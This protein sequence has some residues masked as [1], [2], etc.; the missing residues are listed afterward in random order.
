VYSKEKQAAYMRKFRKTSAYRK[1]TQTPTWK[2]G[3]W[4]NNLKQRYGVSVAWVG[5]KFLEQQGKCVICLQDIYYNVWGIRN[6]KTYSLHVDHEHETGRIRGLLCQNCNIALGK[7]KDN[8]DN[9]MRAYKY[10]I[11]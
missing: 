11:R 3:V 7:F 4:K 1:Q 5:E 8:P 6:D 9:I 2:W 10:V